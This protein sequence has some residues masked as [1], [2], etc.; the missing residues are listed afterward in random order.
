M[1]VFG[2]CRPRALPGGRQSWSLTAATGVMIALVT[3]ALSC[4]Q[5]PESDQPNVV[6]I[7]VD[8][9]GWADTAVYGSQFYET[10][11]INE[12]AAD[13][14]RFTRAYAVSPVCSPSRSALLSGNHPARL[15]QTNWIPGGSNSPDHRLLEVQDENHLPRSEETL[16]EALR[17]DGYVTAH[18]GKWHLG[19]EGHLPKDQGFDINVAGNRNGSPPEYFW[20]YKRGNYQLDELA[21]TGEEGEYLTTRLGTE[22]VEFIQG[23]RDRP[24]FLFLSHYAVHTPLQ[25][26]DSLVQKYRT[27]R[28]T[29]YWPERP[30]MGEE[31]G[32]KWLMQQRNPVFAAM[33]EAMD[34]TIGRVRTALQEAGVAEET[35]VIFTS[36]NGGLATDHPSTSNY[37]LR[38]GKGWLYEGGVRVPQIVHWPGVTAPGS[39]S[40]A[41]VF[42][43]DLYRTILGITGTEVPDGQGLDGRSLVPELRDAGTLSSRPLFW[44]FPHYHGGGN[45]PSAALRSGPFKLVQYFALEEVE[46]YD[47]SED[48]SEQRDLSGR[49]P[50]LADSLLDRLKQWRSQVDAQMPRP[51][52][53]HS[54]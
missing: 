23:H 20:P 42:G 32:H 21:A 33:I 5:G 28:D 44:H 19:D 53:N 48:L 37:P 29:M 7:V 47:L 31:H 30:V 34:R 38:A 12:L 52:P 16:A 3:L 14:M 35:V 51:N 41:A 40:N 46:L 27:K 9:L 54:P 4:K 17:R 10:P 36:D 18:M 50:A 45:T 22:A 43:T 2:T 26:P 49:R 24:F 11:H 15:N 8:D 13:G 39:T 1:W 6:L 25:A